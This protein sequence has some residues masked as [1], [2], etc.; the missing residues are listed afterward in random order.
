MSIYG[1]NQGPTLESGWPGGPV[2]MN[3]SNTGID[4][5]W[6]WIRGDRGRN[7]NPMNDRP[8][9]ISQ[10]NMTGERE[11]NLNQVYSP[12]HEYSD[13]YRRGLDEMPQRNKPGMLRKILA[14][15]AGVGLGSPEAGDQALYAPYYR[16]MGDWQERMRA[17]QPGMT[18]ERYENTNERMMN[19]D[20][21]ANKERDRQNDIRERDVARRE[22]LD[23]SNIEIRQQRADA[24]AQN[25]EFK[26]QHPKHE[27]KAVPGG[28]YVWFNPEDPE[29]GPID[30]GIK[31]GTMS[32]V[33][34]INLGQK[35][36]LSRIAATGAEARKTENVREGNRQSDIAA[37]GAQART[38]KA[39]A[40]DTGSTTETTVTVTDAEGKPVGTRKTLAKKIPG[41][42]S[43]EKMH[44]MQYKDKNTGKMMTIRVPESKVRE[45]VQHGAQDLGVLP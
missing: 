16:Q 7:Q 22:Q 41:T 1:Q 5:D 20:I 23:K 36:A 24:Y 11:G 25:L 21:L 39:A 13:L 4:D 18:A 8:P 6:S 38:T 26:Q 37:R 2:R 14:I 32:K 42:P 19:R 28:N 29:E 40:S 44:R 30:T 33:E 15:T 43:N 45:A 17:L 10:L 27:L 3:P 9:D 35:N 12:Q 31:T 34:E